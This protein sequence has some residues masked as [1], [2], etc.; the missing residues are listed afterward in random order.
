MKTFLLIISLMTS[1]SA[2]AVTLHQKKVILPVDISSARLLLSNAGYGDMYILKI[3]IPELADMTFLN[4]RNPTAGGPCMATYETLDLEAVVQGNPS[5]ENV[6]FD[7]TLDKDV[8]L[9]D[10]FC[11]VTMTE[12][13][14]GKIRGFTFQHTVSQEMPRRMKEDCR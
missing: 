1:V 4:H 6:E 9:N 10:E 13:V 2:S 12:T 5:V 7:I 3:I 14:V 8:Y 11:H